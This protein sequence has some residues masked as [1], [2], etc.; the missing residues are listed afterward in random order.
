MKSTIELKHY[1]GYLLQRELAEQTRTIYLKQAE[2]FLEFLEGREIT[3]KESIAY[4]QMLVK[5]GQ[6]ISTVNLYLVALNSY[7][8]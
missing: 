4:K 5:R 8:C 2:L 6:K 7:L 3:K 1:A